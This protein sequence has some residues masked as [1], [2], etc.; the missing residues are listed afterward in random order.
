MTIEEFQV[1]EKCQREKLLF[2]D[3]VYLAS[4][5]E[6]EF[7]ID[8][9]QIHS[10]YIEAFYHHSK[11]RLIYLRAFSTTDELTPYLLHV[12]LSPLIK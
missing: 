10:F 9:Y 1:M 7:V 6:P 4:R 8:L 5:Q 2:D 11:K 12:D 3:G